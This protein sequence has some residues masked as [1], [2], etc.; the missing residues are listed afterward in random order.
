MNKN[1]IKRDVDWIYGHKDFSALGSA[2]TQTA[3]TKKPVL[4]HA[5]SAFAAG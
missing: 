3:K 1:A 5:S 4:G 2:A